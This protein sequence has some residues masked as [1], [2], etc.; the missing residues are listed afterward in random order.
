MVFVSA[1]TPSAV[2]RPTPERVSPQVGNPDRPEVF[3]PGVPDS[4]SGKSEEPSRLPPVLP[5]PELLRAGRTIDRAIM[6]ILETNRRQS[7]RLS[8]LDALIR[9]ISEKTVES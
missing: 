7:A 4:G 3:R 8:A 1:P 9:D 5:A 6:R 2:S